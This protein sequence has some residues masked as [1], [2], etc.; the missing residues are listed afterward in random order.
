MAELLQVI[1]VGGKNMKESLHLRS[2][3]ATNTEKFSN[4]FE[5]LLDS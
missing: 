2:V 5:E 4:K 1:N 3:F